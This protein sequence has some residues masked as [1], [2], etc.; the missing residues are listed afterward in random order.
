MLESKA[1]NQLTITSSSPLCPHNS[2]ST[3]GTLATAN[4]CWE[5][6]LPTFPHTPA[7]TH[8]KLI[9]PVLSLFSLSNLQDSGFY[10]LY[11]TWTTMP[12]LYPVEIPQ[13][14]SWRTWL[15][16]RIPLVSCVHTGGVSAAFFSA[17]H[18]TRAWQNRHAPIW[19]SPAARV[20]T[21]VFLAQRIFLGMFSHLF[22][23][24]LQWLCVGLQAP[25]HIGDLHSV[26]AA[27]AWLNRPC[28]ITL[29]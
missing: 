18:L 11:C 6:A 15:G 27:R 19:K 25:P 12:L 28:F 20:A 21:C 10:I 1:I 8:P 2:V 17:V 29:Y 14:R 26:P 23:A 16:G 9:N 22:R 5:D 13:G 24:L 7:H 3:T 4:A